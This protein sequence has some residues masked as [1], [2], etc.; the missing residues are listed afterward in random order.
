MSI[1]H[2]GNRSFKTGEYSNDLEPNE[3]DLLVGLKH[4]RVLKGYANEARPTQPTPLRN[5][6]QES[7]QAIIKPNTR[8][9]GTL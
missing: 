6:T 5:A 1:K 9:G 7:N 2:R 8:W 4:I 3:G